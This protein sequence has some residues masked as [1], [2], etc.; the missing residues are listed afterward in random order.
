MGNKENIIDTINHV[1]IDHEG[2]NGK[3]YLDDPICYRDGRLITGVSYG[4]ALVDDIDEERIDL[5]AFDIDML[6]SILD[7]LNAKVERDFITFYVY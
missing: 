5:E 3:A 1:I 6:D 4:K 7:H 2:L